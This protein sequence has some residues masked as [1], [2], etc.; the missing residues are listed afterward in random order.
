ME[1]N[2]IH[3]TETGGEKNLP[4]ENPPPE[5][6]PPA[7]GAPPPAANLVVNGDVKS[8]RELEIDRREAATDERERKAREIEDGIARR[9][10]EVQTREEI[11]R[12]V[13]PAPV[14]KVKRFRIGAIINTDPDD[15]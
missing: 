2:E 4:P 14:K 10:M 12:G 1:T 3:Q 7:P 13:P 6:L 11:L 15:E 9:E 5:N 8:E